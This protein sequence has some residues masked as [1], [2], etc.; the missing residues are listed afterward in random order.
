MKQHCETALYRSGF[1]SF[2]GIFCAFAYGL[3]SAACG[4]RSSLDG[5][6]SPGNGQGAASGASSG[7]MGAGGG[8][9]QSIPPSKIISLSSESIIESEAHVATASNGFVAVS[10]ISIPEMEPGAIGYVFSVN[11]G[12]SFVPPAFVK[13]PDGRTASDP[14]LAVDAQKNFYLTWVG[15]YRDMNG[16]PFDMR[17]YAA[18]AS[19]GT[20][21]FGPPIEVSDPNEGTLADK[22]WIGVTPKGAILITYGR[23]SGQNWGIVAARSEDGLNWKRSVIAQDS[24]QSKVF[25]NL[26]FPCAAYDSGAVY[27]VYARLGQDTSIRMHRSD[28]DGVSWSPSTELE[29][30]VS[31]EQVGYDGPSCVAA[32][33]D[34]WVSYGLSNTPGGA[35]NSAVLFAVRVARSSDFGKSISQRS[36]AHDKDAAIFYLHPQL[37]RAEDGTLHLGYY[38]GDFD[39]DPEGSMRRSASSDL[40]QSF[41]KSEAL[42][43][44]ITFLPDRGDLRWLGDYMGFVF[45]AGSLYVAYTDNASGFAHIAFERV[46]LP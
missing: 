35:E 15:F 19:A 4:A 21:V 16:E 17:I 39:Q 6:E 28:D 45:R 41:S 23:E 3:S 24:V 20:T 30:N 42:G 34:V 29:V 14:V 32:G 18:K 31:K 25:R 8:G 12:D 10:W 22:P 2:I 7:N 36:D 26:A 33:S 13:S 43:P 37:A 9:G 1:L 40:G 44:P 27:A 11:K 5:D 46:D 38:A